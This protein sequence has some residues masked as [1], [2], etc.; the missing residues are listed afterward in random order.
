[1][2]DVKV[3]SKWLD[4]GVEFIKVIPKSPSGKLLVGVCLFEATSG[5][6]CFTFLQRRV[7]RDRAKTLP[8]RKEVFT[9][10]KL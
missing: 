6:D 7:L 10:S 5:N 1:M 2:S 9:V 3:R 4:G 8:K